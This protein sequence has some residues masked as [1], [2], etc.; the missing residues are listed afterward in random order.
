MQQGFCRKWLAAA[1]MLVCMLVVGAAPLAAQATGSISGTVT[2]AVT[3]RPLSGVRI[4]VVG[5][6]LQGVSNNAGR[7]TIRQVPV[8]SHTRNCTCQRWA[9]SSVCSF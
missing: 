7:Y 8:G 3:N 6:T 5:T 9:Q 1:G 2:N 4:L